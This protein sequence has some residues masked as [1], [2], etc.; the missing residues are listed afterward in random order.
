M[1]RVS[2][3]RALALFPLAVYFL[4]LDEMMRL[5]TNKKVAVHLRMRRQPRRS[6]S[7]R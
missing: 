7:Q 3:V 5:F 4:S 2:H 6:L 1:N